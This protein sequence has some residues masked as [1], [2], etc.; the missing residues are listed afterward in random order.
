MAATANFVKLSKFQLNS[1]R[2]R[3]N[4]PQS[5]IRECVNRVE[6]CPDQFCFQVLNSA[7]AKLKQFAPIWLGCMPVP[8]VDREITRRF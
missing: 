6:W 2:K 4:M 1:K 7:P 3:R 5:V 8:G